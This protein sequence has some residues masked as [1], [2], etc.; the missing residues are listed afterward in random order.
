MPSGY[1][2]DFKNF[3]RDIERYLAHIGKRE[4]RADGM[5]VFHGF[6]EA[7]RAMFDRYLEAEVL[8]PLV[9]EF[10][11]WNWE[12]S[13]D[14][15]LLEL[16]AALEKKRDWTGL[17]TLW[18]SVLTKRKKLYNELRKL[19]RDDPAALPRDSLAGARERLLET[20][21]RL[22]DLVEKYGTAEAVKG[23]SILADKVGR[24]KK[25]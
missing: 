24:R 4:K 20:A 5:I 2:P 15:F 14:D 16:T 8:E 12:Y 19:D 22:I 7:Q 23:Y 6:P 13:Y 21:G 1:Q 11:T 3:Q 9:G 17:E 10:K 18:R 25:A